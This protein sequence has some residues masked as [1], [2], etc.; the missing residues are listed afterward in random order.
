MPTKKEARNGRADARNAH[1][2]P[3]KHWCYMHNDGSG[4]YLPKAKFSLNRAKYHG[5]HDRCK[6]CE[7]SYR[8]DLE[9]KYGKRTDQTKTLRVTP[10]SHKMVRATAKQTGATHYEVVGAAVRF[11]L[12]YGCLFPGCAKPRTRLGRCADHFTVA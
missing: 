1:A 11:Y 8:L 7:R 2:P 6:D 12:Q 4:G 9:S 10:S 5:L 3:G